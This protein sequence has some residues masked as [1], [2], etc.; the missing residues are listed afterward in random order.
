MAGSLR[1]TLLLLV[2][3]AHAEDYTVRFTVQLEERVDSFSVTVREKK[4]PLASARFRE[5]VNSGFFNGCSF[6]R[7]LPAYVWQFGLSGNVTRQ[8]EWD[9]RGTLREESH[10]EQPDWNMRGTIAFAASDGELHRGPRGTQLYIN[11]DD[12]QALDSKGLVP[13]GR[14]VDGMG[15]LSAVYS[16]YRD[17]PKQT[18]IHA[19]GDSYLHAE[20][21]KLSYI[22]RAQQVAFIE[23]PFALSKNSRGLMITIGMVFA[24]FVCCAALSIAQRRL[25]AGYKQAAP[26]EDFRPRDDDDEDYGEEED[27]AEDSAPPTADER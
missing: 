14:V 20:F 6:F 12:N 7:V 24:A 26:E 9:A 5:L 13:F 23:E 27:G 11:N 21:P 22:V 25:F 19:R 16:G 18:L 3:S 10:I 8:R 17:R 2:A 15:T 1:S 4:S